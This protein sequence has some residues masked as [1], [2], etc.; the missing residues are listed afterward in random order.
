M[1]FEHHRLNTFFV[2]FKQAFTFCQNLTEVCIAMV[3]IISMILYV[4]FC[5]MCLESE[6]IFQKKNAPRDSLGQNFFPFR[7]VEK[8]MVSSAHIKPKP[9][10]FSSLQP[11]NYIR[12]IHFLVTRGTS[13]KHCM[14]KEFDIFWMIW[15]G[16]FIRE[17][18]QTIAKT[19]NRH[20]KRWQKSKGM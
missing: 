11:S 19:T 3:C 15:T 10:C 2:S 9:T 13:S 12:T 16:N 1:S 18:W 20:Q 4:S 14:Q 8:A 7:I 17:Q 5:Q 6:C